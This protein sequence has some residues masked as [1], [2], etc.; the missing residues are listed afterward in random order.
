M[1]T[2]RLKLNP[3]GSYLTNWSSDTITGALLW[4]YYRR[5]GTEALG[6]LI[7]AFLKNEPPF[8]LSSGFPGDLLPRPFIP[9]PAQ[10]ISTLRQIEEGKKLKKSQWVTL[11]VFN[12]LRQGQPAKPEEITKPLQTEVVLHNQVSRISGSTSEGGELYT[13]EEQFLNIKCYQYISIYAYIH[14]D[15]EELLGELFADLGRTGLGARASTGK[16]VFLVEETAGFPGFADLPDANSYI[17]L[18]N[19][20]PSVTDPASGYYKLIIKRGRLGEEYAKLPNPFKKPL[21][22][23]V[24]GSVLYSSS[25]HT[26]WLGRFIEDIAPDAPQA[27][28]CGMAM[29]VPACSNQPA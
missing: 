18:G 21:I 16:G 25:Q 15:W 29:V 26:K 8:V 17:L 7:S 2:V 27:V 6:Q 4:A 1:K 19:V 5:F 22:M 11:N 28:H 14:P 13:V 23:L 24:A 10:Q 9:Q 3:L 12:N 20:T